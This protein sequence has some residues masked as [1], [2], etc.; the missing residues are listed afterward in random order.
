M[1]AANTRRKPSSSRRLFAFPRGAEQRASTPAPSPFPRRYRSFSPKAGRNWR[2]FLRRPNPSAWYFSIPPGAR[3]ATKHGTPSVP[4]RR[5]FLPDPFAS[6]VSA[7]TRK[8]S[9]RREASGKFPPHHAR[10]RPPG[11]PSRPIHRRSPLQPL[12]RLPDRSGNSSGSARCPLS[13]SWTKTAGSK[14]AGPATP[15]PCATRWRRKSGG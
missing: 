15:P 14:N 6:T 2:A 4:P 10:P 1:G 3:S 8:G 5:R 13:C 9:T 7:S 11:W 12:R